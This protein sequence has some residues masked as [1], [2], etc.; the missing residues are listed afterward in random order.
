MTAAR[1]RLGRWVR[2][3]IGRALAE[4]H[5]RLRTEADT[6]LRQACA[7]GLGAFVGCFPIWGVHFLIC[8]IAARMLRVS[9]ITTYLAAHVS[10]P[11][12]FPFLI[13]A[14]LMVGHRLASGAWPALLLAEL[15]NAGLREQLSAL[16]VG[17]LVVGLLLGAALGS[18][19]ALVA[20]RFRHAGPKRRLIE[21]VSRRFVRAGVFSWE[22]ARGKLRHDDALLA[23][24]TGGLL[25]ERGRVVD[26]GCGRGVFLATLLAARELH[27]QGEWP[28]EWSAPSSDL[29]LVGVELRR[30]HAAVARRALGSAARIERADAAT[31]PIPR[32]QAV[33]L[34]DVLH[35][36]PAT[37]QVDLLARTARAL[38]GGGV[39]LLREADASGGARF[40][41][42]RLA[43][44][45]CTIARGMPRQRFHWRGA[46]DWIALLRESGFEEVRTSHTSR[47]PFANLLFQARI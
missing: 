7:V 33:V 12:T 47:G 20:W 22:F 40:L 18:I 44:R 13:W 25:P 35:Y 15:R 26:I 34:F 46:A 41:L 36:M 9:R 8:T 19:A 37:A 6:P 38:D 29:E 3:R 32:C 4:M 27:A 23:A 14:E 45:A 10:N 31:W 1:R 11:L 16:L 2:R 42:T 24:V 28:L 17:S 5:Y 30:K 39:L 43:E 21:H